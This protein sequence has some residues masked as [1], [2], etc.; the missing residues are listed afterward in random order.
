MTATCDQNYSLG[1][2]IVGFQFIFGL[3]QHLA[4]DRQLLVFLDVMRKIV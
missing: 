1:A 4:M 2:N 3:N